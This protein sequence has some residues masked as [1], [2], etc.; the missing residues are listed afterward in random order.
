[1]VSADGH[2]IAGSIVFS[3]GPPG[4]AAGAAP[5]PTGALVRPSIWLARVALYL[6]LFVGVGGAVFAAWIAP[7]RAPVSRCIR[8]ALG[9]GLVA[10]AASIGL[11]GLDVLGLEL[12]AFTSPAVW[13]AGF[14][15]SLGPAM[16]VAFGAVA[17]ADLSLRRAGR[18]Q[19]ALSGAG[20]LAV[21]AAFALTGHASAAAPQWLTRP[22]V[23]LHAVA[24]A[25]WAGAL[26]PLLALLRRREPALW[27]VRRFS[28][29]ALPLVAVLALTG[30]VLAVVQIGTGSALTATAYGTVLLAKLAAVAVLLGLAVLNRVSLTPALSWPGAER[31]LAWSIGAE[32]ALMVLVLALVATWRFTPPPRAIV[33]APRPAPVAGPA[34]ALLHG[35]RTMAQVTLTPGRVGQV[36]AA[37]AVMGPD[38]A[39]AEAREVT[40]SVALPSVG[41]EPLERRAVKAGSGQWIVESL[42]VPL[43]GRWQVRVDVLIGD[44][45]KAVLEGTVEIGPPGGQAAVPAQPD[46]PATAAFRD[47]NAEMH[48]EM[49]IPFS[50]DADIDFVRSMIP[51]HRAAIDMARIVLRHGKDERIRRLAADVV[52]EQEREIAQMQA[53]LA[54]RG[55]REP[56]G[57]DG[58]SKPA[59]P[60]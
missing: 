47:V 58:S 8:P 31:R 41:I 55:S 57:V 33:P 59:A 2:P 35:E 3:I 4:P 22:A 24:V 12:P 5:E 18:W 45:E 36:R 53:W 6:G 9:A 52:R 25:Y 40:L 51:H 17:V 60:R 38:H 46:T 43:P 39:P 14:G 37:I 30:A 28:A 19:R 20:L 21:G 29:V 54:K 15:T 56:P 48:R 42:P 7:A 34:V 27:T 49:D 44:F 13:A 10:A 1:M 16:I 23:F 11:Q 26:I 50:G 32:I